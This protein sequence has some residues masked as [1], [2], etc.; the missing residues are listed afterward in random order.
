MTWQKLTWPN[1]S[2]QNFL[3]RVSMSINWRPMLFGRYLAGNSIF[4]HITQVG[5]QGGG[6]H[7]FTT[8]SKKKILKIDFW[9]TIWSQRPQNTFLDSLDVSLQDSKKIHVPTIFWNFLGHHAKVLTAKNE[10]WP[11]QGLVDRPKNR[12][13]DQKC[14]FFQSPRYVNHNATTEKG[15]PN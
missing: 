7:E 14:R 2:R 1:Y 5:N 13:S 11:S 9:A 4:W 10:N 3:E 6:L 15:T 12:L 8:F